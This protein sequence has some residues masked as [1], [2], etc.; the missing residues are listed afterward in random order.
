M[1]SIPSEK[2]ISR[3]PDEIL[4]PFLQAKEETEAQRHLERLM[5]E[6]EPVIQGILRRR[7]R[8]SLNGAIRSRKQDEQRAEDVHG[9]VVVRLL[10]RLDHLKANAQEEVISDFRGFVAVTTYHV[11]DLYLRKKYPRRWSLKNKLFYLLTRSAGRQ[12]FAVWE[13]ESG[14]RL[15]G[16]A[17]WREQRRTMTRGGRYQQLLDHPGAFAAAALP[18][19]NVAH[20]HPAHLLVTLFNWVGCPMELDDLVSVVADLWG[21][22][23]DPE[24]PAGAGQG[25]GANVLERIASPDADVATEVEQR[26]YLERLWA[27]IRQL[28]PR[29]CAALLLNLKDSQG[30]GV[31]ALLPLRGIATL[32]DIAGALAMP[33]EQFALLWND[34]PMDDATIAEHLGFTRQQVIN[35]RKVARQRLGRRM[36]SFEHEP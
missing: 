15:C 20:L 23:D 36:R 7:W 26:A 24:T 25:A 33:A 4:T 14:E 2:L 1:P 35:L 19:E 6:A 30:H 11:C 18:G 21:V 28:P 16:L 3:R 34:L 32:G 9:E 29:Q 17:A 10:A 31:I 8:L 27:E 22:K 5:D 13:G 12:C